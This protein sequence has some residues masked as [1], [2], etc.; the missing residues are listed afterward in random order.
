MNPTSVLHARLVPANSHPQTIRPRSHFRGVRSHFLGPFLESSGRVWL[1]GFL[2]L[3]TQALKKF[4]IFS[5]SQKN[6]NTISFLKKILIFHFWSSREPYCLCGIIRRAFWGFT[7]FWFAL[8]LWSRGR[9]SLNTTRF[10][11]DC[12]WAK[13]TQITK[14]AGPCSRPSNVLKIRRWQ[15]AFKKKCVKNTLIAKRSVLQRSQPA[16]ENDLCR[17][18]SRPRHTSARDVSGSCFPFVHEHL[19][20][21]T[22]VSPNRL[23]T[24]APGQV[25][26]APFWQEGVETAQYDMGCISPS[27]GPMLGLN[28]NTP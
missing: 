19:P 22:A 1:F 12:C 27:I 20:S 28:P 24:L 7:L 6:T 15:V 25:G 16:S 5:R 3:P 8:D 26:N 14:G 21:F 9:V 10:I 11:V 4:I 17:R 13:T 23:Q 2:P 18:A